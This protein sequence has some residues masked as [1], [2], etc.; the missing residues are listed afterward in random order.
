MKPWVSTP[1]SFSLTVSGSSLQAK[2]STEEATYQCMKW[3][4][5]IIRSA[6][7]LDWRNRLKM[8]LGSTIKY[9]QG[10]GFR[11]TYSI[12]VSLSDLLSESLS[13]SKALPR[14]QDTLLWRRAVYL[15][16]P[17]WSQ[18]TWSAHCWLLLQSKACSQWAKT[19]GYFSCWFVSLL[20]ITVVNKPL[21]AFSSVTRLIWWTCF[22]V[23]RPIIFLFSRRKNLRMGIMWHVFSRCRRTN[24]EATG[25]SS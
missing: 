22:F 17:H 21:R 25:S 20:F 4:V 10:F 9:S 3:M 23:C 24:A 19:D 12:N 1:L 13:T 15:L 2:K 8:Y 11:L 6:I 16:H 5:V 7:C 18:Q 14:P